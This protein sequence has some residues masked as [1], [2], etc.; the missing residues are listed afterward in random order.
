MGINH[1]SPL[2][3]ESIL[4]YY[5]FPH[6][7]PRLIYQLKLERNQKSRKEETRERRRTRNNGVRIVM[8]PNVT[9]T[10]SILC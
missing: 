9:S 4:L 5:F 2:Y 10:R 3:F 7:K 8:Y 1:T 6:P